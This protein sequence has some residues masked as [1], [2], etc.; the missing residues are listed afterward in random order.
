MWTQMGFRKVKAGK[1][2][3]VNMV[4]I[5][6]ID[7]YFQDLILTSSVNRTGYHATLEKI[8]SL[9]EGLFSIQQKIVPSLITTRM[10]GSATIAQWICLHLPSS[11]PGFESQAHHLR[12]FQFSKL[13]CVMWKRRK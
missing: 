7:Q 11:R 8:K 3:Y 6:M 12:F 13:I 2:F 1:S 10:H 5:A 4:A 9:L